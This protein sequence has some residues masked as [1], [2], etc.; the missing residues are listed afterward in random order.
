MPSTQLHITNSLIIMNG[1][2]D[3]MQINHSDA[4]SISD[5]VMDLPYNI[6]LHINVSETESALN[7]F[8]ATI[9]SSDVEETIIN[10]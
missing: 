1:D 8:Y 5:Y 9:V 7:D 3:S 10:Q 4:D 2:H 6:I